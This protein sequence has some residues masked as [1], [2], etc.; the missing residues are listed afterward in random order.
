MIRNIWTGAKFW[1][2]LELTFETVLEL[3]DDLG[4]YYQYLLSK[5]SKIHHSLYGYTYGP[6][7]LGIKTLCP[8]TLFAYLLMFLLHLFVSL[9][10]CPSVCCSVC[11]SVHLSVRVYVLLSVYV[12]VHN[13]MLCVSS[14]S[15]SYCYF[16]AE[17]H[18]AECHNADCCFSV[19]RYANCH[20]A[21]CC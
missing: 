6:M 18:Y 14:C 4:I 7:P 12:S 20:Y 9:Y 2:D 15:V 11:L 21:Q 19:C 16:Y 8:S 13:V 10:V 3:L 17:Y 1:V 5:S